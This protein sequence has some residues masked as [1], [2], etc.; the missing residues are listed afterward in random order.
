VPR[1]SRAPGFSPPDWPRLGRRTNAS[2]PIGGLPPAVVEIPYAW[3][4]TP[5]TR[6]PTTAITKAQ[7]TQSGGVVAYSSAPDATARQFGV[8]TATVT[9][10]TAC[11]ADP[12]NLATFLTTYQGAPRPRQPTLTFNLLARTD[13]ECL[14][15]LG[16]QLAQRVRITGSPAG[17]PPGAANFVVE[18]I[19][20]ALGVDDRT[21]IWSTAALIGTPNLVILGADDFGRV[22]A[23]GWGTTADGKL[24]FNDIPDADTGVTG[25][26][27]TLQPSILA[28]NYNEWIAV[29]SSDVDNR[30]DHQ[31]NA[32]PASGTLRFGASGRLTDGDNTYRADVTVT[33][34]GS[35]TLKLIRA[36][37]GVE[38]TLT[39]VV[40]PGAVAPATWYTVQ[41]RV[42]GS[43]P[44]ATLQ[45]R[46][47]RTGTTT[48]P[49]QLTWAD[50]SPLT[51]GSNA[52]VFVRNDTAST[53]HV[54]GVDNVLIGVDGN[55]GSTTPGPWFRW[56]S[57]SYGGTDVRPF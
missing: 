12:Q 14:I 27:G 40:L 3:I 51:T 52:G 34:T 30:A 32:L 47:W 26:V 42:Y 13:A 20:H 21:V 2:R 54:F 18:G 57:S 37:A 45:A 39:S 9:L 8:N 56:G 23:G 7:V 10:D 16:V 1:G 17:T 38:T 53:A 29:G 36:N 25:S 4:A 50:T 11:D 31:I 15:I 49:Y 48:P 43:S 19:A 24:W 46:A 5:L 22:V 6:K 41:L 55:G 33:T 44:Q 35:A 28:D